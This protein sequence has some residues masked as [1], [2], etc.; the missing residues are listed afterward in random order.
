MIYFIISFRFWSA[1]ALKCI[2]CP[3]NWVIFREHCYKVFTSITTWSTAMSR[4]QNLSATLMVV[5][6]Q[7]EYNLLQSFYTSLNNPSLSIWV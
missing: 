2:V 6:D 7:A 4:C 1:T 3:A 5:R